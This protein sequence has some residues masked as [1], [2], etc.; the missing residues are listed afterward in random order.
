[1]EWDIVEYDWLVAECRDVV[2]C[3]LMAS[4]LVSVME[5]KHDDVKKDLGICFVLVQRFSWQRGAIIKP[6]G[7][8]RMIFRSLSSVTSSFFI[9]HSLRHV[10]LCLRL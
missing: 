10:T 7:G 9:L 6:C 1:M 3:L 2:A 5:V 8:L 4:G